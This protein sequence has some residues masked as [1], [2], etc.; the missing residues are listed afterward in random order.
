MSQKYRVVLSGVGGDEAMGGVPIPTP[1]LQDLLASARFGMLVHQLKAWALQARKPWLHLLLESA[2]GFLPPWL[3]GVPKYMRPAPWLQ[4]AFV[5]RNRSAL[6][7]YPSRVKLFGP[8]G[9]FHDNIGTLETVRRQIGCKVLP[10]NPTYETRY[11]YLD[12]D[13]LEFMYAIPREQSVRPTQ[14][15]SLMRRALVGIVP[16]EIL[17]RRGKA[18]VTRTPLVQIRKDWTSLVLMTQHMVSSSFGIV[19]SERFLTALQMGR[20]GEEVPMVTVIRMISFES[21]LRK[22]RKVKNVSLNSIGRLQPCC[23]GFVGERSWRDL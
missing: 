3:V 19:D 2:R 18:P 23:T 15:R 1:E 6:T 5:R 13:L 22:L 20:Q 12:R 21:W 7:G 10:I 4:S 16:D 8:L 14:R 17:N 11:P 9:S